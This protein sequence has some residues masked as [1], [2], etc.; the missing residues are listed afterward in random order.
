MSFLKIFVGNRAE[1][2]S[3]FFNNNQMTSKG[4]MALIRDDPWIRTVEG[5]KLFEMKHL[6][7]IKS[8]LLNVFSSLGKAI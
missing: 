1:E 6:A 5:E 3:I 8:P 2:L 7:M 4:I